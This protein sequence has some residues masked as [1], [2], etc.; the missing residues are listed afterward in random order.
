MAEVID[1]ARVKSTCRV[2]N[3][4]YNREG[5]FTEYQLRELDT[6]SLH[7]RGNWYREKDL[8]M[9]RRS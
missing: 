8:R 7:N 5:R 2:Y 4:R 1:G 9:D 3:S 6:K